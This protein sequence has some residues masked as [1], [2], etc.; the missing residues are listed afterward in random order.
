MPYTTAKANGTPR[1]TGA[2]DIIMNIDQTS[3][4][5]QKKRNLFTNALLSFKK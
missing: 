5:G 1:Y 2:C 3:R 4:K